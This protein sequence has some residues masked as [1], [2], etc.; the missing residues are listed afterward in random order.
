M[1]IGCIIF[2]IIPLLFKNWK[3]FKRAALLDFEQGLLRGP[4]SRGKTESPT[5]KKGL[6]FTGRAPF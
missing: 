3:R 6:P 1:A 4:R 5:R 2:I